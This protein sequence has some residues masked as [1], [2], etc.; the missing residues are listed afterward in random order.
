[1]NAFLGV[2]LATALLLGS[3]AAYAEGEGNNPA[4]VE[5]AAGTGV[6]ATYVT[7]ERGEQVAVSVPP[8]TL[9]APVA[10]AGPQTARAVQVVARR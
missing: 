6:Y 1:M 8:V 4:A 5:V 3:P 7:N 2:L 9:T 10:L